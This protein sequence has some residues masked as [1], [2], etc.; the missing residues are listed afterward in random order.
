MLPKEEKEREV[1]G[2][3]LRDTDTTQHKLSNIVQNV[4]QANNQPFTKRLTLLENVSFIEKHSLKNKK[5]Q[6]KKQE[7]KKNFANCFRRKHEPP[8]SCKTVGEKY[9]STKDLGCF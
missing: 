7:T 4:L 2:K 8:D 3:E 6:K 1:E 5:M 9:G